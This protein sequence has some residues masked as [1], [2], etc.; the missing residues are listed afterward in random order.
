MTKEQSEI[1]IFKCKVDSKRFFTE[2]DLDSHLKEKH[3][4]SFKVKRVDQPQSEAQKL[5]EAPTS[6]KKRGRPPKPKKAQE[7]VNSMH[8]NFPTAQSTAE[9]VTSQ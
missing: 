6:M 7:I 2:D 5:E 1:T 9:P 3:S 8:T 4:E